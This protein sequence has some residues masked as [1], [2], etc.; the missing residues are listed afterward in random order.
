MNQIKKIA[1]SIL[2]M[3]YR[4]YPSSKKGIPIILVHGFPYDV[5]AYD[6]VAAILMNK[7]YRVLTPYLRGYGATQFKSSTTLRSGQQAALAHDILEF[8]DALQIPK[9]I[10]GG[11][12]WG[13]RACCIISA[14]WPERVLGLVSV[15]GY[16]IQDIPGY[17]NPDLPGIEKL[18]WYQ[19]YFHS[20]RGRRGLNEHRK[21]LCRILWKD[22]SPTWNF[23]EETYLQSAISFGNH[24]FVDVVVHSYR[25]R[26]GLVAGDPRYEKTEDL[27][28]AQPRITV[29]TIVLD[30]GSDGVQ[31]LYGDEDYSK[32]FTGMYE[33]KILPNIGHNVP[34]E[35]PVEFAEAVL[36]LLK[37]S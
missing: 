24:D 29:P 34:Q 27:L 22:W 17:A 9:A 30:P 18:N 23:T 12:D 8:M 2:D 15:S 35:A 21:D 3:A 19:Y 11:Y 5:H 36:Q 32:Y 6:E 33:R 13:G 31:P 4:E 14:L 25:H 7:G 26:Y 20:E 16:N 28:V 1:T 10:L 37:N